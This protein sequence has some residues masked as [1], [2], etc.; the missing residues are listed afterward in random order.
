[1]EEVKKFYLL[2][3]MGLGS[4]EANTLNKIGKS[5]FRSHIVHVPS[6]SLK[7]IC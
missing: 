1:M 6:V 2:W 5:L 7:Y 3:N 4:S